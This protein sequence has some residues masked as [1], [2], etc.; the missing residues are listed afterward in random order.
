MK[1]I[2]VLCFS[3]AYTP[4][5]SGAEI[6]VQEIVRRLISKGDYEFTI[7][8]SRVDTKAAKREEKK[9]ETVIRVGKGNLSRDKYLYPFQASSAAK[10]VEADLVFV[11]M[12]SFAAYAGILYNRKHSSTP[13][14]L[15]SQNGDTEEYIKRKL[16]PFTFLYR[17]AYSK[18]YHY[19]VIS[20]FLAK[21]A[22]SQ[23]ISPSRITLV[24]NGVNSSQFKR[25]PKLELQ[26]KKLRSKLGLGKKKVILTTSRLSFKNGIDDCIRSMKALPEDTV[27]LVVGSGEDEKKL[28]ALPASTGVGP[29]VLFLGRLDYDELPAYYVLADVFVRPSISEGFGNSFI[30]ALSCQTPIVGTRVG[31]IPDFL[32][33]G[34]TGLFC[35]VR[36]PGDLAKKIGLLLAD[37]KLSKRIGAAG[38]RMVLEKYDWNNVAD[39]YDNLFKRI[40]QSNRQG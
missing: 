1:R 21:R 19:T 36:N 13:A 8:T 38:R 24:P 5:V 9:H 12:E 11:S 27:L 37:P 18:H 17:W 35:A 7:I 31:G 22:V 6:A 39:Q 20:R 32:T 40:L 30:E 25:T 10:Q 28:K 4:F 23:G 3:L 26:A 14:V 29:R 2:R 33:E 16:W 15:N 34:K